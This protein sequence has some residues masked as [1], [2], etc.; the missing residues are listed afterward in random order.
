M[1]RNIRAELTEQLR[2]LQYELKCTAPMRP[3]DITRSVVRLAAKPEHEYEL[4]LPNEAARLADKWGWEADEPEPVPQNSE[5]SPFQKLILDHIIA[6]LYGSL[7]TL[8]NLPSHLFVTE[9]T[10][11]D[12]VIGRL[13][14]YAAKH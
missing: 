8:E 4:A 1:S 12:T 7:S 11:I 5:L 9:K 10:L 13:N 6:D 3:G 14:E 2:K